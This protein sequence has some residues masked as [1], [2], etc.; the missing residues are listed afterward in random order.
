MQS[1]APKPSFRTVLADAWLPAQFKTLD[2][3]LIIFAWWTEP[4]LWRHLKGILLTISITWLFRHG[5]MMMV[6]VIRQASPIIQPACGLR[7]GT[8]YFQP[9]TDV[10]G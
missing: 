5:L 4:L 2:L 3:S 8:A 10:H 6:R 7:N 9:A 1:P